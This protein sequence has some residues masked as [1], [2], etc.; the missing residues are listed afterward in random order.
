MDSLGLTETL[1]EPFPLAM[2][3]PGIERLGLDAF[4]R[5]DDVPA[6]FAPLDLTLEVTHV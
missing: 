1:A 2:A 3:S 6:D 5:F 4:P